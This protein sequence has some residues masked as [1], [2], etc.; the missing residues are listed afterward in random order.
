MPLENTTD[1]V[2]HDHTDRE[3]TPNYPSDLVDHN[4]SRHQAFS[5]LLGMS[6]QPATR[7]IEL[8]E[9]KINIGSKYPLLSLQYIAGIDK[10]LGSDVDYS[11]WRFT[12]T[13]SVNLRLKGRISYHISMGGFIDS[14]KV[15][16]PDYQH[17]NGNVSTFATEYLN[18]FQVLPIYKYS[19]TSKFY[20]LAHI[21]YHLNGFLT[22]KIPVIRKLN[23]HLVAG[24][25]AFHVNKT[26]YQE[27]LIGFENI[28]KQFRVDFVSSAIN[29]TK[30]KTGIRI[31]LRRSLGKAFDDWP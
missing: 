20:V 10:F 25:N 29:G 26:N 5:I 11:K 14:S 22:N 7:Y 9:R 23:W 21:E 28:F 17:F 24:A 6:W 18:S 4:I 30:G 12:L 2:W 13:H 19:N 31:G 3:F 8:P 1:Y 16:V 27:Y 15:Q